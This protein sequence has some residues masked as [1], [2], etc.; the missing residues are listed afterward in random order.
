M[1]GRDVNSLIAL[2]E[3]QT[4]EFKTSFE[5][6]TIETLVAFA[7][8][9]GGVVI[10]GVADDGAVQGVTLGKETL[11]NWLVQIKSATSPSIIPDIVASETEG[12]TVVL[13]SVDEYPVKPVHTRGKY[14][15]RFAASN[16]QLAL[17][18]ITNLYMQ[19]LQLSWDSYEAPRN[20]LDALSLAKIEKFIEQVN[21]GG[22][23]SLDNSP[24]LALEKLK[25]IVNNRPTWAALLLFAEEPLR[26]H[27]HIGRF[28]TPV[29]IIDD[30]QIT[31]TLFE[32][33]EQAMK[34]IVSHINVA[35]II[36]GS[37]QRKERFAY[38]LPALREA[39]LN[40]IVHRD[41]TNPSDIL[42]KIFDDRITI[43]SP[44]N[45]F[46]G[47]TVDDLATDHYQSRLRN[48][49]VAEAFYLTKNIEKYGSGFIRIRKELET[50]PEIAFTIEEIGHGVLVSFVR[51]EGVS[52][53]VSGGVNQL[54]QSIKENPGLRV[55]EL[56]AKMHV[57][58]KT[59]ERWVK[60]LRKQ[61]KIVFKGA[62]KTGGYYT[63]DDE[64]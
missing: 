32:A 31:G 21:L 60:Q 34:F 2:G 17:S 33:V 28:K 55:P 39:L 63:V 9:Q 44:G 11:N 56:S 14:F 25:Y 48:K 18:E 57:P 41:Y 38:P 1:T 45:L 8:T 42:V 61:K 16:H 59:L 43:F 50:Y 3:S 10:V 49:L 62:P 13:L 37:L 26:H 58:V 20:S 64:K 29:M 24:L 19:S 5:R 40:A 53:G 12:K 7:N 6:E 30:R 54:H 35:F 36:N 4:L 15:K 46:G 47:L 27:I 23:F 22:R 52:G 51:D